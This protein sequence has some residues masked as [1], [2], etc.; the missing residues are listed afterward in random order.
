MSMKVLFVEDDKGAA[1]ILQNAL[2]VQQYLVEQASDGQV[3]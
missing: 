2:G 1:E 3:G